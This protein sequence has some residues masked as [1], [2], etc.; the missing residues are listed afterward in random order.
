MQREQNRRERQM[1]DARDGGDGWSEERMARRLEDEGGGLRV[2]RGREEALDA[3]EVEA[4]VLG[5]GVVARDGE[6]EERE[7]ADEE[8]R[9][10]YVA[11]ACG[12]LGFEL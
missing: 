4:A 9:E 3:G 7:R 2:E 11:A 5:V 8:R 6:C 10:G 12:L 1:A